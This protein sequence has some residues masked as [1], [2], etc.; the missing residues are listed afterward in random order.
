MDKFR[1]YKKFQRFINQA[2]KQVLQAYREGW[3]QI[4]H[5]PEGY[6][7]FGSSGNSLISIRNPPGWYGR[8]PDGSYGI[9]FLEADKGN[10]NSVY[11]DGCC[12]DCS[13]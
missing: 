7:G 13:H 12:C 10:E 2:P 9:I 3:S 1:G 4:E 8:S 6:S 11:H 5:H